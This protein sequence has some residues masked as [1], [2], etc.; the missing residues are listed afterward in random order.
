M[1]NPK[2]FRV[3][4]LDI[5]EDHMPDQVL[6]AAEVMLNGLMAGSAVFPRCVG[7]CTDFQSIGNL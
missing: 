3:V 6:F 1:I 7:F 4:A 2:Y 5:R